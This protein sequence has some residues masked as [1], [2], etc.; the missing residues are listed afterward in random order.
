MWPQYIEKLY[1]N[2][3]SFWLKPDRIWKARRKIRLLFFI[4]PTQLR[5]QIPAVRFALN[6]FVWAMRRML[7]QVH[8]FEEAEGLNILPGSLSVNKRQLPALHRQVILGLVLLTGAFP[9]G[10]INPGAH[11]FS[12]CGQFTYTHALLTILWMFGF[13]RFNLFLKNL[14]RCGKFPDIQLANA[15][16]IDMAASYMQL[17]KQ[18]IKYDIKKAPQHTCFLKQQ[19]RRRVSRREIGDLQMIGCPV[20][21]EVSIKT[22]SVACILGVH[23]RAGQWGRHPTC[24][25]VFTCVINRRSVYGYVN[26]FMAVDGDDCPG[27]ASVCWFGEPHYPLGRDNRLEVVVSADGSQLESEIQSCIIRITQIDPSYI[28]VEPDGSNYRMMRQ[29]GYDRVV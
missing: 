19:T 6:T 17:F 22:F 27:Y 10:H 15:V 20:Q 1:Y 2:G 9:E 12:H 18:G 5:D 25:S 23:F 14:I 28:V 26:Q 29:S 4:L 7:G 16:A 11:H 8:C 13:E 21:G 3:A 24:S